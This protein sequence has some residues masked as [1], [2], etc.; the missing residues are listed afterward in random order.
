[1][2]EEMTPAEAQV[3]ALDEARREVSRLEGARR[4]LRLG[5]HLEQTPR[6]IFR[7]RPGVYG[8]GWFGFDKAEPLDLGAGIEQDFYAF[9]GERRDAA[10]DRVR[11]IEA[12]LAGLDVG[13]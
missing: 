5:R 13:E 2:A 8:F 12:R 7:W 10:E 6:G 3:R 9:L 1:V 4:E 11:E